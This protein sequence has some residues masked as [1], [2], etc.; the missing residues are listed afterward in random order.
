MTEAQTHDVQY[1][2]YNPV[3]VANRL[4]QAREALDLTRKQVAEKLGIPLGTLE[5]YETGR[6]EPNLSRLRKLC[7]FYGIPAADIMDEVGDEEGTG[8]PA[9]APNVNDRSTRLRQLLQEV[10][11]LAGAP[12][13][14][15]R[16]GSEAATS[17]AVKMD[18]A[19]L[20]TE[21]TL[22]DVLGELAQ[23]AGDKQIQPRQFRKQLRR[24]Q[25]E[26]DDAERAELVDAMEA[27]GLRLPEGEDDEQ[28][29][30]EDDEQEAAWSDEHLRQLLLVHAVYGVDPRDLARQAI[31]P[32]I[33]ALQAEEVDPL[34]VTD[35][36]I[37]GD[38]AARYDR[39]R[40]LLPELVK[41]ARS[42]D[43]PDLSDRKRYPRVD[44]TNGR[45]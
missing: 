10:G 28:D 38:Q 42:A 5:K 30:D 32:L 33:D 44:A 2:E 12:V 15:E 29:D 11:Q 40:P 37:S 16:E 9:P 22:A 31:N 36:L 45:K 19:G 8:D 23:A 7:R 41:A 3:S 27:R 18:T 43:R 17:P 34:W 1:S 20:D 24:V 6:G 25:E 21:L 13:V 35:G 39:L 4:R 26:L 14:I